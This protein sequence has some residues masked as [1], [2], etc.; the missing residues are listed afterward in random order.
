[1]KNEFYR[2]KNGN[3]IVLI[4][5][6]DGSK[7]VICHDDV[8]KPDFA[9]SM[10]VTITTKCSQNCPFCYLNCT[11]DGETADISKYTFL[12][13]L[14]PYTEMAINGNDLDA[15]CLLPLLEKLKEQRVF[16]NLT[17]NQNQFMDHIDLLREWSGRRLINGLGVSYQR[18]DRAFRSI[19]RTFPNAVIHVVAGIVTQEDFEFLYQTDAKLL[20]L[21]YKETGRGKTWK[22]QNDPQFA[23]D[24]KWLKENVMSLPQWFPVVSFDNKACEQLDMKH[25]LPQSVWNSTYQGDDGT[26]TFYLDLVHGKY[27][28][29]SMSTELYDI[30]DKFV[31]DMFHDLQK[32]KAAHVEA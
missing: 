28:E 15:P 24:M 32:K 2:Y 27:A 4:N 31:D 5:A 19:L 11:S 9:E 6:A 7:A 13:N 29:T 22:G 16:A 17:V 20:I 1:M 21:G 10:D 23:V 30:G 26:V 18:K 25:Q 3:A 8:R 14:H 12:D